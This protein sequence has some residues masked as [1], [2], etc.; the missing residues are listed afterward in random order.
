MNSAITLR[1]RQVATI[2]KVRQA[3]AK[4]AREGKPK[5]VL[6]VA[7]CGFGKTITSSAIMGAALERGNDSIFMADR[8]ILV[9]QKS[10]TLTRCGI[11]HSVLMAGE[12]FYHAQVVVASRD[13]YWSRVVES[14]RMPRFNRKLWIVDEA[15]SQFGRTALN[16]LSHQDDAVLIGLTATPVLPN[17]TGLGGFWQE[18]VIGA[19]YQELLDEGLLVPAR[20]F[21]PW[22][23][24]TSGLHKKDG[25]WSWA[26]VEERI[27]NRELVGDIVD[28]YCKLG[29]GRPFACFASGVPHSI[30]LCR[31]FN[32]RGIP[33]THI[34]ADT[35]AEDREYAFHRIE[36][37]ELRGLCNFGV[38]GVGFDL[39]ILSCGILGFATGSLVKH[40]QVAG[41]LLRT[42]DSK[43]DALIID[44]GGNVRRH[45]WPTEDHCW[46]LDT[47]EEI[48]VRDDIKRQKE[49]KPREPICCPKC[50][51]M[52]QGGAVCPNC[53]HKH[54]KSGA[55]VR[56]VDGEFREVKPREIKKADDKDGN[57][58]VWMSCLAIAARK[59]GNAYMAKIIYA[60]KTG[61][62]ADNMKPMPQ[63][64]QMGMPV[65]LV[66]PGFLKGKA[67]VQ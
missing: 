59:Q 6:V 12:E 35:P 41:R 54:I 48:E 52:R 58:R 16:I 20:V 44:H 64:H 18:M 32:D 25:D 23:I 63:P 2:E 56:T 24:D 29:E 30:E 10:R 65:G 31:E 36:S 38:L 9:G 49:D 8:R 66:F 40:L 60:Q 53:G 57:Q 19:T 27:N 55:K 45:G 5:R 33:T 43:T 42:H 26:K 28:T 67:K 21:A 34:D 1:P 7:P 62:Q 51:A 39:P 46:S 11:P 50:A 15:H 3:I 14:E 47:E 13:T 22:E 17:G 4:C 37:G 61:Q